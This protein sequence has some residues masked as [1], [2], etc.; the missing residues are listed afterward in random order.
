MQGEL[1]MK[2]DGQLY[3]IR[4]KG[5]TVSPPPGPEICETE[6]LAPVCTNRK[7]K[8]NQEELLII[9]LIVLL[10]SDKCETDMPLIIALAYILL[11]K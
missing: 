7:N 5:E 11:S 9:G 8:I 3:Q 6:Q 1:Y 10:L 2:S 4:H